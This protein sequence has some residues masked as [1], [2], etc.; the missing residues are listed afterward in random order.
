MRLREYPED[1]DRRSA[2]TLLPE[3]FHAVGVSL[4]IAAQRVRLLVR[5]SSVIDEQVRDREAA[6]EAVDRLGL[7]RLRRDAQAAG[8]PVDLAGV[9]AQD[10]PG[11]RGVA[12]DPAAG[13]V[14]VGVRLALGLGASDATE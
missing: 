12:G 4:Y 7:G 14:E 11:P 5:V 1:A 6:D 3:G 8:L 10:G 2:S 13:G 9:S